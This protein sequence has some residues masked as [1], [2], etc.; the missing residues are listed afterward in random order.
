MEHAGHCCHAETLDRCFPRPG[1]RLLVTGAVF[2]GILL[3][4]FSPLT[5]ALNQSLLAY[6]GIVWLF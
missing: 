3:L 4:S 1:K 6:L 2:L 5:G